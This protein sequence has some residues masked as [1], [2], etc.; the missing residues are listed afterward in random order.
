MRRKAAIETSAVGLAAPSE[1]LRGELERLGMPPA[2]AGPLA[3]ELIEL[4]RR[5]PER[6]YRALLDGVVLGQRVGRGSIAASPELA[7]I[8]ENFASELKKLDEGL[9]VLAAYLARLRE[10][11]APA[12]RTLH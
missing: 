8:L 1:Q 2:Q 11:T 5:L 12:P 9:R 7:R 10:Q 6:E 4:A 3:E